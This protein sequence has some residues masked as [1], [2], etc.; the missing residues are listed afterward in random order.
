ML[1]I[2]ATS[3]GQTLT[4]PVGQV[5]ELRLAENPTTGFRWR[6][7][8]DGEPACRVVADSFEKGAEG[9]PGAGG[10]H[11]WTIKGVQA[12]TCEIALRYDRSWNAEAPPGRSFGVQVRVTD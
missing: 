11:V 10:T 5:L 9:L 6:F 4:L 7:S 12:G 8:S 3:A 2:D 1:A